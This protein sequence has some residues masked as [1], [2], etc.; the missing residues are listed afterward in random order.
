M[1]IIIINETRVHPTGKYISYVHYK[2]VPVPTTISVC[3]KY[4]VYC[5]CILYI[6]SL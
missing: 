4:T 6:C 3:E 1:V 5:F 2:H